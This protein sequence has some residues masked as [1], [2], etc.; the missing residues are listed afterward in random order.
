MSYTKKLFILMVVFLVPKVLLAH[1]IPIHP[2]DIQLKVYPTWIHM[3][4]NS[5]Q[6]YWFAEV[7]QLG[8]EPTVWM[9][10]FNSPIKKYVDDHF[11]LAIDGVPL[12][13]RMLSARWDQNPWRSHL[14][15]R[16][17][18]QFSYALPPQ[19]GKRLEGSATFFSEH[20]AEDKDEIY[21]TYL[22]VPGRKHMKVS[23]PLNASRFELPLADATRTP[24][25]ERMDFLWDQ[26]VTRGFT[27]FAAVLALVALYLAVSWRPRRLSV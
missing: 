4:L 5:N 6:S 14:L 12:E 3:T 23:L 10:K 21:M 18:F 27:P 17:I 20:A 15:G 13:S 19:G 9:E 26:F 2:V 8:S 1:D 16:V 11:K 22:D 24:L 7:L 25:Q